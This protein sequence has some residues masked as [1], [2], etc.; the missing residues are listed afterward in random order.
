MSSNEE[1][2]P[3]NI[4]TFYCPSRRTDAQIQDVQGNVR[5][6]TDF[7]A[8]T[9][10]PF[11]SVGGQLRTET[12]AA[13]VLVDFWKNSVGKVPLRADYRGI[14]TR[15]ASTPPTKIRRITDGT[16]KT[17]ML[18]EKRMIVAKYRIGEWFD[19]FGWSAGWSVSTIRRTDFVPKRDATKE[20]G[21]GI[22]DSHTPL[23]VYLNS[24]Q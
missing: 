22:L 14:V 5:A 20:A 4:P 3:F 6:S 16:S 18:G 23:S 12:N 15:T 24:P 21:P 19:L 1:M 17:M 11:L 8:P 9:P 13:Q 7:S 2:E 10:A